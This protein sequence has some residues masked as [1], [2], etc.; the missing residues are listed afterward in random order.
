MKSILIAAGCLEQVLAQGGVCT[1]VQNIPALWHWLRS[2]FG[3]H[4]RLE[5]SVPYTDINLRVDNA[6]PL[7]SLA[8]LGDIKFISM[9]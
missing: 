2:H 5:D 6:M 4:L 3:P 1:T 8:H 7:H 9:T